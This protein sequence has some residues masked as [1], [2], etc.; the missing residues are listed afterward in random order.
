M[1][2]ADC[3]DFLRWALPRLGL[4][5]TGFRKVRGT[6][7]KRLKRRLAELNLDDLVAY[8]RLID[9]DAGERDR[10]D[11][12]C[13]IPISRFWRDRAVFD[14]LGDEVL[15]ALAAAAVDRRQPLRVSSLGCASGEEPY[16]MTLLWDIRCRHRFPD[17]PCMILGT[18]AE[19]TMLDR[20]RE[21]CYAPGSLRDLPGD[22]REAFLP[23][24]G[25]LCLAA[26]R[27]AQVDFK[28]QDVRRQ[29]PSG[30]F[31]MIMCRNIV[32]TY[33]GAEWQKRLLPQL[34]A[35]L[36]DGGAFVI[37]RHEVLPADTGLVPWR[38]ELGIFRRA[39]PGVVGR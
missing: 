1:R 28:L 36:V 7:C 39:L 32:L 22:L 4:R 38:P 26:A 15:P 30:S 13:R 17:L 9:A 21:G 14:G 12:M 6:V 25:R 33:F 2:D 8:R 19:P 35:R 27:W 3:V 37:G 11:A 20:A 18:D 29:M 16:S 23:V 10:L 34:V 5:W 31:D 24:D